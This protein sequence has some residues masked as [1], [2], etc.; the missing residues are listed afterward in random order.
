MTKNELI[1]EL[2]SR[3]LEVV[4]MVQKAEASVRET[5]RIYFRTG[6]DPVAWE[7]VKGKTDMVIVNITNN[8]QIAADWEKSGGIVTPLYRIYK[9]GETK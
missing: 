5:K 4:G 8:R 9:E 7:L 2:A 6:A 1:R 3:Y